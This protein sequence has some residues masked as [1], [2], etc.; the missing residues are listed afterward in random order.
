[1]IIILSIIGCVLLGILGLLIHDLRRAT[2]ELNYINT[3]ETNALITTSTNFPF[4]ARLIKE[5]N[6]S[7]KQSR[8]IKQAGIQKDK[9]IRQMLTNLT[10]DIKTPLTVSMG[11]VQLMRKDSGGDVQK[12]LE[13]V[14]KNLN[15][16]DYY[17]HYLMDFNVLQ[18]KGINL[19]ITEV[20]VAKLLE[21]ELFSFYDEFEGHGLQVTPQITSGIIIKTDET[22]LL[23][24]FQN[25][26]GNILKY[27][28]DNVE[29]QL[30]SKDADHVEITF[31]NTMLTELEHP[32]LLLN[33][34]YTGDEART[35]QS[36]GIGLS[37]VQSLI[38]MLGGRFDLE[39][40]SLTFKATIT[41]KKSSQS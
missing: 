15:S 26:I 3:H 37:I 8:E 24:V 32:E 6:D 2:N 7:L 4:L 31:E 36:S 25:L 20:D 40:A 35:N 1:M 12:S 39:V 19:E 38:T 13:K 14:S 23:R 30:T 27:A 16:V 18:E 17:L 34:F 21:T 28:K 11:Y 9:Q 5:S 10:H 22:L 33:R 29:V 41:L